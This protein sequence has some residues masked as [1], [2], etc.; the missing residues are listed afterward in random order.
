M[1][2]GKCSARTT[3]R[4]RAE[5]Q[6]SQESS[7]ALAGRYGLDPKTV[8]KYIERGIEA[9]AYGPRS[10]GRPCKL[11]PDLAAGWSRLPDRT[12]QAVTSLMTRLL[13][14]HVAD[15]APAAGSDADE[16]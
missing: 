5:L 13:V 10:V 12:R 16:R 14:G 9:P 8:R 6:A 1:H 11:A 3:P 4:I 2:F 15:A 7:R